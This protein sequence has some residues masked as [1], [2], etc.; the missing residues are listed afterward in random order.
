MFKFHK[1]IVNVP[2]NHDDTNKWTR[3]VSKTSP[4]LPPRVCMFACLTGLHAWRTMA[5]R[6]M[7]S[8]CVI[9]LG[10]KF[11]PSCQYPRIFLVVCK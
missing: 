3:A 9:V 6:T 8:A 2:S 10:H 5:A 4:P 7:T 11:S 1:I